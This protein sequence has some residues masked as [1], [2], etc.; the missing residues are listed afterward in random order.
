MTFHTYVFNLIIK[1]I[2]N[3]MSLIWL[4]SFLLLSIPAFPFSSSSL[5]PFHFPFSSSSSPFHYRAAKASFF[6]FFVVLLLVLSHADRDV[7]RRSTADRRSHNA[8]AVPPQ[9][10]TATNHYRS[11]FR[12]LQ[13]QHWTVDGTERLSLYAV[14]TALGCERWRP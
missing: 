14:H 8:I 3:R 1:N 13:H 7:N 2:S 9:I 6:F 5:Q 10:A 12:P 11:R 4:D